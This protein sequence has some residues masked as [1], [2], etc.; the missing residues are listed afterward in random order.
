[1]DCWQHDWT[2]GSAETAA[3]QA[4]SAYGRSNHDIT[5][6]AARRITEAPPELEDYIHERI[7]AIELARTT[8]GDSVRARARRCAGAP[9]VGSG[10]VATLLRQAAVAGQP[11]AVVA[12]ANGEWMTVTMG[13]NAARTPDEAPP[14][15]EIFRDPAFQVWRRDAVALHLSGLESGLLPVIESTAMPNR[16]TW[17]EQLLPWDP[18]RQAAAVRALAARVGSGTPP[19]TATLGLDEAVAREAD[20]LSARWIAAAAARGDRANPRRSPANAMMLL[21]HPPSCD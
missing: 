14:P 7:V 17:L 8:A 10:E 16:M 15:L 13:R 2:R 18:V 4:D 6:T 9:T 5:S 12:Y 20:A 11:D 21:D 3:M 1:M 19:S